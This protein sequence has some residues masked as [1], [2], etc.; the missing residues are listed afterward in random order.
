MTFPHGMAPKL[1]CQSDRPPDGGQEDWGMRKSRF[2][3]AQIV[4]I[5]Q[6]SAAGAK[7]SE[8]LRRHGISGQT[9]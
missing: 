4:G 7:T 9:F 6:E 5:L 2:T 3:E 8:L 1:S